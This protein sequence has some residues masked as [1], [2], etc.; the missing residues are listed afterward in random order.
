MCISQL[1]EQQCPAL[2]QSRLGESYVPIYTG[3]M[4]VV[5]TTPQFTMQQCMDKDPEQGELA[6]GGDTDAMTSHSKFS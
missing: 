5:G 3:V 4:P 1:H 2:G 6:P